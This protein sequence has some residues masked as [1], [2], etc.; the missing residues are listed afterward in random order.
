[1]K[2]RIIVL[3]LTLALLLSAFAVPALADLP[4]GACGQTGMVKCDNCDGRGYVDRG[5]WR[6]GIYK[7]PCSYCHQSGKV[8][9]RAC[10]GDGRIGSGDSGTSGGGGGDSGTHAASLNK[11]SLT[12]IAGRSEALQVLWGT[13]DVKW[14]SSKKAVASVSSKGVVKA[15]KAGRCTVTAE[16][17]G[18]KLKCRVTVQ[19]KVYAKS[20]KL[21]RTKARLLTDGSVDLSYTVS[22]SSSKI[23]EDWS[24]S[25]SSSNG[26]VATVGK[27]GKVTAHSPGTATITA[28]L[29]IKKGKYDKAKC[30]ITVESGLTRFKKWFQKNSAPSGGSKRVYYRGNA[31]NYTNIIYNSSKGTW[32]FYQYE[33]TYNGYIERSITFNR[34]FT[35]NAKLKYYWYRS[36]AFTG[37]SETEASA[38]QSVKTLSGS[39]GYDWTFTKGSDS[40]RKVA[41]ADIHALLSGLH[42]FLRDEVKLDA[43]VGWYDL[44]LKAY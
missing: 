34:K 9:C 14:S 2:K 22:P 19:K 1:M 35:G 8:S 29:K 43:R 15:K 23:T 12:L 36:G 37:V 28:K 25:W 11:T 39:S 21:N 40:D 38:T 20:V 44:G 7:S 10:G 5:V 4:C 18:Q 32:E 24:V 41:D 17:G 27:D 31:D 3:L 6:T 16:V 30:K 13:G 42:V 33:K 26:S